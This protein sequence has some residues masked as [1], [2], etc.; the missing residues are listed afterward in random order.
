M[1]ISICIPTY[2]RKNLLRRA[3]ESALR[4]DYSDIEIIVSDN[5]SNDGTQE[6]M[7][8]FHENAKVRYYKNNTNIGPLPNY[9]KCLYEY[10]QGDYILYLS[11]DDELVDSTYITQVV[12]HIQKHPN[13]LI[14]IGNTRIAYTDIW[15]SFDEAKKLPE[16]TKWEE[17]FLRY[18]SGDYT[19]SWC[20]AVFHR[21]TAI[22]IHSYEG[23][24]FYVDSDSFFRIMQFGDVGFIDTI[25]SIYAV[26][27]KNS[28]K[29]A[30]LE[31]YIDN[32]A[33]IIKN[34]N[35]V[36]TLWKIQKSDLD[37]WKNRLLSGYRINMM[38]NLILFSKR[39]IYNVLKALRILKKDKYIPPFI[40]YFK[41]PI[42]YIAR[43][44]IKIKPLFR[45]LVSHNHS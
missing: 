30:S 17:F 44:A 34:Y 18:G 26:H 12:T 4:Q 6:S 9:K 22:D 14:V 43:F 7:L 37:I 11:D 28:Y 20:N 33:Y 42:L 32:Q 25:A 38:H 15:L 21:Q 39:P 16:I 27:A 23:D 2:N 3:I 45:F 24:V 5:N 40:F 19:I 1:K 8:M 36:L 35:Y 13:S 41:I 29:I 10:A 31:T